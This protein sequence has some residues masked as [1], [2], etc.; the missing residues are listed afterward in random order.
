MSD[1]DHVESARAVYDAAA[2]RYVAFVGTRISAATE[3]P[4]DRSLLV[5]FSEL[6]RGGPTGVVAD[7][8]CG[9]GRVAALLAGHDLEVVGVDVSPAMLEVARIAHPGIRFEDGRLDALPFESAT[10]A[11]AVCWYSVIYSPPDRLAEAFGELARVVRPGGHVLLGF[12]CGDGEAVHRAA[13]HGTQLPLTSYLHSSQAVAAQLEQAHFA[14]HATVVRAAHLEHETGPQ[15]FVFA[16][17][18]G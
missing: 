16:R 13:A 1:A 9:P 5:A 18:L 3:A 10:V 12:Q 17:R 15:C 4:I 8:G 14:I 11:G 7:I 2:S 6:I